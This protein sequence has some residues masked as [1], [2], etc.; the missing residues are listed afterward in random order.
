MPKYSKKNPYQKIS[1]RPWRRSVRAPQSVTIPMSQSSTSSSSLARVPRNYGLTFPDLF[2]E[3]KRVSL[4]Y[5]QQGMLT[6]GGAGQG[7]AQT[8]RC[9]GIHDPDSSGIGH[10][11]MHH[12]ILSTVY[13]RYAV[14]SAKIVTTFWSANSV[15]QCGVY[16]TLRPIYG[17]TVSVTTDTWTTLTENGSVKF[18]YLGPG[19]GGS[20]VVTCTSYYDPVKM[21]GTTA[22]GEDDLSA[23]F[24]SVPSKT[25]T[26][27]VGLVPINTADTIGPIRYATK[28]I[29]N[30]VVYRRKHDLS[31]D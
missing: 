14:E 24:G 4:V 12:D 22:M 18:K 29:Y 21:F 27:T 16:T 30:V 17:D 26:W 28:I 25:P 23:V 1:Q 3:V 19:D 7:A 5:A 13:E 11:P 2:P 10:Q 31:S 8:Y 9:A 20:D 6:A 15:S